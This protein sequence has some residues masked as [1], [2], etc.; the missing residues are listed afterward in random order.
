MA[1]LYQP[2]AGQKPVQPRR[3]KN[4]FRSREI[5]TRSPAAAK[6][7]FWIDLDLR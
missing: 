6:N 2:R 5:I 7:C 4:A 3:G 1:A